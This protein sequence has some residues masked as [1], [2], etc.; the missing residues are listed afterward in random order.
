[1]P[2][3]IFAVSKTRTSRNNMPNRFFSKET[4][5]TDVDCAIFQDILPRVIRHD[6]FVYNHKTFCFSKV[7]TIPQSG[8]RCFK[9][10]IGSIQ[11]PTKPTVELF[12]LPYFFRSLIL[13]TTSL[14][15]LGFSYIR[16][17]MSQPL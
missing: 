9:I 7:I 13:S 15:Q 10:Y 3:Q 14:C 11:D 12:A 2:L 5:S 17:G 16:T 8:R 4:C 1:M 6:N